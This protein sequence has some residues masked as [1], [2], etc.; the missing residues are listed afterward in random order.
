MMKKKVVVGALAFLM[1]TSLILSYSVIYSFQKVEQPD[2]FF[3]LDVAYENI[4]E[5]KVLVDKVSSYTNLFVI[6]CT[7]ITHDTVKLDEM[8]QYLYDRGFSFI[9]Y[10]E[11][12]IR[13]QWLVDAKER[14]GNRLL[15]F[16]AFDEAGGYQLDLNQYRPVHEADNITDATNQFI[17]TVN[18]S[19][20]RVNIGFTESTNFPL[21]TSDYA[22]YWFDYKGGYDVVLA[23][24]GWNYSRQLN[25]GMVRGAAT[26]QGKEWGA[27]VTWTY[28]N[29]PYIESGPELYEDLVLAYENGA[30]YIVIFDSDKNYMR[31][32]LENEHLEAMKTFWEYASENPRESH[33]VKDRLAFVLPENFAYGFR[34]PLDKIWGLWEAESIPEF[35]EE[36]CTELNRLMVE[37]DKNLDIIYNDHLE[38]DVYG[39]YFFWNETILE[40]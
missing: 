22:F 12:S 28:N 25:V 18:R 6:G 5:I 4:E 1:V 11:W 35:S 23:Q 15:G 7:G 17:G 21:F 26:V 2:L 19:L 36:L 31:G 16:Y 29:P 30:K 33:P 32:I 38:L 10:V 34:G 13:A 39:K 20:N 9:V 37:Y 8:C 3:G 40:P 14:W 24:L 27:I